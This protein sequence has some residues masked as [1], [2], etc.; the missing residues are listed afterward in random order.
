V[1]DG[2]ENYLTSSVANPFSGLECSSNGSTT[3]PAQLLA[4]F[5]EFPVGDSAS[6]WNGSGGVLE[7]NLNVGSSYFHSLN[8]RLQKRFS[9]GLSFVTN[10][11]YSKLIEQVS[12]LNDSAP[13]PEKR[14]STIDHPQR[15]V[16]AMSYEVP[17][18]RGRAHGIQSRFLDALAGGW[19]VNNVFTWQ[20]GAPIAWENG[21]SNSPGDYVYFGAPIDLNNRAVGPGQKAFNTSGFDTAAAY[22]LQYHIRTFST[23][24]SDLR[25]DG[26]L[27][28]DPSLLKRFEITEKV[29]FQLRF[30]AYNALNRPTFAAPSTT[31]SNSAFGTITATA[32]RFRTIQLGARL[33]F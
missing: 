20:I 33:V 22:A 18:G 32:N 5:P 24:F 31:A 25:T 23:T 11:V 30:E 4:Q 27:Q 12:W 6:G 3:T 9:H 13:T 10:Y 1:R 26:I 2:N 14:I 16:L 15:I 17:F 28:W 8:L 29:N 19:I 21:S 7:Q